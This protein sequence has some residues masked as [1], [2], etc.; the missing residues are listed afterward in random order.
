MRF[1]DSL[2]LRARLYLASAAILFLFAFNVGTHLWGS[3]AR[4]ESVMAY[5]D[6][7][8][9]ASLVRDIEQA[10]ATQYQRVQV[11][12]ALRET[13]SAPLDR[14]DRQQ[15]TAQLEIIS[16]R[17]RELGGLS[18]VDTELAFRALYKETAAL[19]ESWTRFYDN[20]NTQEQLALDG[21][22][23]AAFDGVIN[24]LEALAETQNEVALTRS[25][26]IDQT[27]ELTDRITIIGFVS[28]ITIT[29]I[30][31]LALIRTTNTSLLRLKLGVERFGSGD[32]TYRIE[33]QRDAGE[34]ENLARTFNEMSASLQ[35]A[36]TDL[37][38]ARA[39]AESANEAKSMF[40]ANVSHELR[41]PLNAII[42]YSEMLQDELGDET[43]ID[44]D[45]FHHDLTT[46]I[47]SGRQLLALINDILDLSKIETGKMSVSTEPFNLAG[48]V[49][50]VCDA[51]T[52][53]LAQNGN[54][55][56]LDVAN[57]RDSD[58]HSDPAKVQQI[59]TNLFS[60]ACKFTKQ[61]T[62]S[63]T[64]SVESG[65]YSRCII[66]V[67]DTGIGMNEGQ[68]AKVFQAFVQA[69]QST[70]VNYGG[71]GLGLAIVTNFC[72]MLGGDVSL[73]SAP[74]QG[75]SFRVSLPAAPEQA[76]E[77]V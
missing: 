32:L 30:L 16:D 41:T 18:E 38:A 68:Q 61:G 59:L 15:A 51:L 34:I 57:A 63:V 72:D 8:A 49:V 64:A 3:Y 35:T 39:E 24:N 66:T 11:L 69:E 70:S 50:Q 60:N 62:I 43:E 1:S 10:L 12:S 77:A 74:G 55:L 42:G 27:I 40:L 9:A 7:T 2:S 54:R 47:F 65:E 23:P 75:S 17:L 56:E 21:I 29:L 71:T 4:S 31:I 45:Q 58:V 25:A 46:I 52:P 5:R 22:G 13:N 33:E 14:G 48:L 36:M 20:Y 19:L 37:R 73:E 6:A 28:S 76:R 44:R 26:V 67:S 53:L